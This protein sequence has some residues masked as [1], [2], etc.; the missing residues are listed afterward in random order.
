MG[1]SMPAGCRS[2]R[3]AAQHAVLVRGAPQGY[4]HHSPPR[5]HTATTVPEIKAYMQDIV[6]G[7]RVDPEE[8]IALMRKGGV[9]RPRPG[10]SASPTLNLAPARPPT[11]W[12]DQGGPNQVR[13]KDYFGAVA[14][15]PMVFGLAWDV[16]DGVNIDLDASAILLSGD[17][18]GRQL[19]DVRCLPPDPTHP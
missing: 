13:I 17:T 5:A 3:P 16:T 15:K 19:V 2:H 6:P 12:P 9:V 1:Y 18:A 10:P 7:V 8:R 4:T 14:S 11:L